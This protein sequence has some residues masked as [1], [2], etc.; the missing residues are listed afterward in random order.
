[1]HFNEKHELFYIQFWYTL[2]HTIHKI[3]TFLKTVKKQTYINMTWPGRVLCF[4][5]QE[6]K[7][8][9]LIGLKWPVTNSSSW[10]SLSIFFCAH[11]KHAPSAKCFSQISAAFCHTSESTSTSLH[12]SAQSVAPAAV[13]ST[14]SHMSPRT[15]YITPVESATGQS[16]LTTIIIVLLFILVF[17]CTE[18]W[19]LKFEWEQVNST[20]LIHKIFLLFLPF[21][22]RC[23]SHSNYSYKL[24]ILLKIDNPITESLYEI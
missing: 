1:M 22:S 6:H 13:L 3:N 7:G 12:T 10:L 18:I 4:C 19:F 5:V 20:T 8:H 15:A 16:T 21:P 11:R 14:S 2:Y 9:Y 23:H 17:S 24:T